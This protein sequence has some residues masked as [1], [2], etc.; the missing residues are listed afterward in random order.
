MNILITGA[1][2]FIGRELEAYFGYKHKIYALGRQSLDLTKPSVV[3]KYF[4]ENKI[5]IVM[6]TAVRGGRRNKQDSFNDMHDNLTMYRNLVANSHRFGKLYNFSSGAEFDRAHPIDSAKE[7]DLFL[8]TPSDFYGLSKNI[9]ARENLL[10]LDGGRN[11][12]IFGC[13]SASERVDR[14]VRA[15]I[16]RSET[17]QPMVIHQDRYIDYIY[18]ADLLKVVEHYVENDDGSLPKDIN[19]CYDK[20][21]KLSDIANII[22]GLTLFSS[23]VKIEQ[24]GLDKPYTGDFKKLQSLNL[25]L[26]GLEKGVEEVCKTFWK[27]DADAS[28]H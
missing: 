9:I 26:I 20:K 18:I 10:N 11:F 5:D 1:K 27:S 2:G 19:L 4:A 13:F 15:N 24:P 16:I 17:M 22:D 8:S 6:H 12:R 25:D 14:F 21:Y 3:K 23:G 7:K 28:C